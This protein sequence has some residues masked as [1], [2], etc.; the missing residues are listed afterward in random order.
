MLFKLVLKTR[1]FQVYKRYNV[2]LF[3]SKSEGA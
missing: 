1:D 2:L 3:N